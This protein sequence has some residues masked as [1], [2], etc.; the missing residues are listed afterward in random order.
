MITKIKDFI[1]NR[2]HKK[3]NVFPMTENRDGFLYFLG[4]SESQNQLIINPK[5]ISKIIK[6]I[7]E[8]K[9]LKITINDAYFDKI[10]NLDFLKEI[11][12]VEEI[13]ILQNNLNLKPIENLKKLKSL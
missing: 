2:I 1:K 7:N 6:Y 11:P 8:N 12:N 3:N 13:S 10:Q 5:K 9:I 4:N